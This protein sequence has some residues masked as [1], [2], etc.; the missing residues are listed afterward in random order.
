MLLESRML[1]FNLQ[2]A[3][4]QVL[5]FGG[6]KYIFRGSRFLFLLY[7]SKNFPGHETIW[8][9][10]KIFWGYCPEMP[11]TWLWAWFTVERA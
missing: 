6:A 3:C 4:S 9:C 10:T 5:R 11:P 8:G 1:R 7:V 2:Q